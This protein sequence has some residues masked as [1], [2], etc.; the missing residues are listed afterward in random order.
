MSS[1]ENPG[2]ASF[3]FRDSVLAAK[4]VVTQKPQCCYRS[5]IWLNSAAFNALRCSSRKVLIYPPPQRTRLPGAAQRSACVR[6]T[7]SP[8]RGAA[9]VA[10]CATPLET[11]RWVGR[12]WASA[13][14]HPEAT[15]EVRP[16]EG[17]CSVRYERKFAMAFQRQNAANVCQEPICLLTGRRGRR[18]PSPLG[19]PG[20]GSYS[21]H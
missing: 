16:R 9:L 6:K 3:L 21:H 20:N 2:L 19:G 8:S 18:L 4:R 7:S 15:G 1:V 5:V 14:N 10:L 12:V 11:S 17:V 13:G